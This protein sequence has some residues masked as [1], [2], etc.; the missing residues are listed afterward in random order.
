MNSFVDYWFAVE[1]TSNAEPQGPK[2]V[3]M[4][5]DRGGKLCIGPMWD[6]DWGTF[7]SYRA[8]SYQ[9]KECLYY[10]ELF[11]DSQF[12]SIVK[13]RWPKAKA[14]FE[15]ILEFIDYEAEKIKN[16]EKMNTAMWPISS[17]TNGDESM[18]FEE[19]VSRLKNVYSRKLQWLDTQ[20]AGM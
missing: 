10:P 13:E 2:S 15:K 16:S 9:L 5:K 18:S 1:L 6:Y 8:T 12:V 4:H 11:K 17:N 3:Y 20:I 14:N 7:V 19:A